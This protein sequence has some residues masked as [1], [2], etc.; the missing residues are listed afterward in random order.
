LQNAVG[1]VGVKT[2]S[3]HPSRPTQKSGTSAS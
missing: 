1:L 2:F 3:V